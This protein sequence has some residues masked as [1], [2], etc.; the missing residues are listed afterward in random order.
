MAAAETVALHMSFE[1][2]LS[3]TSGSMSCTKERSNSHLTWQ[4]WGQSWTPGPRLLV[5]HFLDEPPHQHVT[6][7]RS[8]QLSVGYMTHVFCKV[9]HIY[10]WL[11]CAI[12]SPKLDIREDFHFNRTLIDSVSRGIAAWDQFT[13][14]PCHTMFW[15]DLHVHFRSAS[16]PSRHHAAQQSSALSPWPVIHS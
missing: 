2:D 12:D 13:L 1:R 14:L 11:Y 8:K 10:S 16:P 7:R 15:S 4:T 9:K 5:H 6:Y 3:F